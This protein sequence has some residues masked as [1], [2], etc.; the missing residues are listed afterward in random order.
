MEHHETEQQ[1]E[2]M[3]EEAAPAEQQVSTEVETA[4]KQ[5]NNPD[6]VEQ[7]ERENA[8]LRQNA[9]AA[10]RA[11]VR[12]VSSG[13]TGNAPVSDFEKGLMADPW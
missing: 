9:Q 4:V 6:R 11:P 8:V 2:L 5:Q 13:V 10:A 1:V 3:R 12:G 7:L